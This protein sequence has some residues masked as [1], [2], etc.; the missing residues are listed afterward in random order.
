MTEDGNVCDH[1]G[2]QLLPECMCCPHCGADAGHEVPTEVRCECGFL[3]CK[4]SAENLEI[5]CR[6]CKRLVM[7][8][9]SDF[10]GRFE[11]NREQKKSRPSNPGTS[12]SAKSSRLQVCGVCGKAKPN[13]IYGK[14]L[15][16]RTE[17]IKVQYRSRAH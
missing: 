1:C 10:P 11:K 16:C 8:P 13:I 9:F 7:I 17:S 4:L 2:R 12:S 5:K 14:C 6:R 15:D 3:L